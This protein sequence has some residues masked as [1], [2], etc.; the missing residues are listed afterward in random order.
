[1]YDMRKG[2]RYADKR[3][4]RTVKG[5]LDGTG[6]LE[7]KN[8]SKNFHITKMGDRRIF[9]CIY[10]YYGFQVIWGRSV[11]YYIYIKFNIK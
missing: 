4:E 5:N 9:Y 8:L 2:Q 11:V 7:S 6:I 3:K 10:Y 1:M